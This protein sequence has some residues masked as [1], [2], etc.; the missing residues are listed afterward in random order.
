MPYLFYTKLILAQASG[1]ATPWW[2]LITG[3]LAIPAALLGLVYTYR[4]YQKTH[5]EMRRLEL[6]IIEKERQLQIPPVVKTTRVRKRQ[7]AQKINFETMFRRERLIVRS[8]IVFIITSLVS[9]GFAWILP[10]PYASDNSFHW[11]TTGGILL[12]VGTVV[13]ISSKYLKKKSPWF[14][15]AIVITTFLLTVLFVF[16]YQYFRAQYVVRLPEYGGIE[17][18]TGTTLTPEAIELRKAYPDSSNEEFVRM[19]GIAAAKEIW[20]SESIT[21]VQTSLI[22]L[23]AISVILAS[24]L[25]VSL[26]YLVFFLRNERKIPPIVAEELL[27]NP[28]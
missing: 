2:Q 3:I 13:L 22:L 24:V 12:L 18:V 11:T 17:L 26:F 25:I 10:Q 16:S 8:Y 9:I 5:L 1:V 15:S 28:S 19:F 14:V 7:R 23:Y 27:G 4:L 21:F 6:E 20:T